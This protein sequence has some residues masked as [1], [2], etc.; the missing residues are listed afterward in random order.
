[1]VSEDVGGLVVEP[2]GLGGALAATGEAWEVVGMFLSG[3]AAFASVACGED[4]TTLPF[5]RSSFRSLLGPTFT[6]VLFPF[7]ACGLP[8]YSGWLSLILPVSTLPPSYPALA[9]QSGTNIKGF[10]A[11]WSVRRSGCWE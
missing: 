4:T 2:E 3:K 8:S 7:A 1:M 10:G 9:A 11:R 6:P 5:A